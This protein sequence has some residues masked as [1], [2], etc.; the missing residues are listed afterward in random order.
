[1]IAGATSPAD[2]Q[3][4]KSSGF[5]G[6]TSRLGS[7]FNLAKTGAGVTVLAA[8]PSVTVARGKCMCV[9]V[10][11][12]V[13]ETPTAVKATGSGKT[14]VLAELGRSHACW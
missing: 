14:E 5:E 9:C 1:M 12:V 6:C 13:E 2:M 4:Y 8:C 10:R 7:G 11:K 3:S